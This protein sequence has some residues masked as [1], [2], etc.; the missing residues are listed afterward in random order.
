M[1]SIVKTPP[2][3]VD[4]DFHP[5][6]ERAERIRIGPILSDFH[7]PFGLF[8]GR[9]GKEGDAVEMR[10]LFGLCEQHITRY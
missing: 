9:L 7:Q 8:R 6:G 2:R 1:R 5:Q 3:L 4:L 10:D